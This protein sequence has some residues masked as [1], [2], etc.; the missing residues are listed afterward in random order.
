MSG[1]FNVLLSRAS[2]CLAFI[3]ALPSILKMPVGLAG[4]SA[5]ALAMSLLAVAWMIRPSIIPAFAGIITP[6]RKVLFR[7]KE[8]KHTLLEIGRS[9]TIFHWDGEVGTPMFSFWGNSTLVVE[10]IHGKLYVS[11]NITDE[12]GRVVAELIRNEWKV[13]PPPDTWDRNYSENA[14]EVKGAHGRIVLQVEA[15]VDRIRIQGEWWNAPG[16]G[17]RILEN[18]SPDGGALVM[19]FVPGGYQVQPPNIRPMFAYPGDQN[20]GALARA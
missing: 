19:Q 6:K 16:L 20:L 2:L 15:M 7:P 8:A 17:V 14:L 18:P 9:G 13:S 3:V 1:R 5:A 11:T 10:K 12:D 4:L